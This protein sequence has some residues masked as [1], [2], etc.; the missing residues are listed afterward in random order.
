MVR[1][2]T[3]AF[4]WQLNYVDQEKRDKVQLLTYLCSNCLKLLDQ[5][6]VFVVVVFFFFAFVIVV[7]KTIILYLISI[8]DRQCG[9][10]L[11]CI[12]CHC[13]LSLLSKQTKWSTHNIC[14]IALQPEWSESVQKSLMVK[15]MSSKPQR[16]VSNS[17]SV[18]YHNEEFL[19][20]FPRGKHALFNP[21]FVNWS[22]LQ[23]KKLVIILTRH[24]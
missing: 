2:E 11:H 1:N 16:R 13:L 3:L 12:F 8:I 17:P 21:A 7:F 23:R 19:K 18:M 20:G 22:D 5:L 6:N 4:H 24:W 10:H 15:K 9:H 14:R